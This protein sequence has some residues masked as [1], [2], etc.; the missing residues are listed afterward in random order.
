RNGY[1][2]LAALDSR[3]LTRK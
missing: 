2:L 1:P 3:K